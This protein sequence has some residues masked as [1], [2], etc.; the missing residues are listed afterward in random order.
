VSVRDREDG[1]AGEHLADV[2]AS[3]PAV[4]QAAEAAQASQYQEGT[5]LDTRS[6]SLSKAGKR[7]TVLHRSR[8]VDTERPTLQ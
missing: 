7:H 5:G 8:F 3:F 6:P 2:V 1:E 4:A